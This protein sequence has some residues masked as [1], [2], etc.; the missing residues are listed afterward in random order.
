MNKED[1]Q[2]MYIRVSQMFCGDTL[3]CM[4]TKLQMAEADEWILL[5]TERE[6]RNFT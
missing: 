6:W 1:G 2:G 3:F 4:I 5:L